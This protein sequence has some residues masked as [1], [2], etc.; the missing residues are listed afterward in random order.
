M[1][2][3]MRNAEFCAVSSALQSILSRRTHVTRALGALA[4]A[5][6]HAAGLQA[7]PLIN[8]QQIS[9]GS[10]HTCAIV[11]GRVQCWGF[12]HDGQ[13]GNGNYLDSGSPVPVVG[14]GSGV[15]AIS[16]G[17]YHTCAL[18]SGLV[19]CWG[20]NPDGELG[21]G[22]VAD[23]NVP[24]TVL[25][26]SGVIAIRA[27]QYHTCAITVS[28]AVRCWGWNSNG[29]LG[30][31]STSAT[32]SGMPTTVSGIA[33][34]ATMLA[35]GGL[36][37]CAL[38]GAAVKCW[39]YNLD[40]ELGNGSIADSHVPVSVNN[41]S[42]AT[43]IAAGLYHTCAIVGGGAVQCWGYNSNGQLGDTS[44]VSTGTG[45]AVAVSGIAAGTTALAGGGYHTCAIVGGVAKCWG[46]NAIGALG[47]G[48]FVESHV[49]MT[50]TGL[51]SNVTAIS[52]GVFH[53][54]A[55]IT[56][57]G[58]QQARC[59][60]DNVDGEIGL[61]DSIY[62]STP[63]F[64]VGL[65]SGASALASGAYAT[66]SCAIV[67]GSAKCWGNNSNGQLGDGT[68]VDSSVPVAVTGLASAVTAISKGASHTCAVVA[69][70]ALCWGANAS[71]Q[72]G[73]AS[74]I[75]ATTP[76]TAIAS[77]VTAVAA[78]YSHSCA[79][80]A[81]AVKCW[82]SNLSGELGNGST[83]ESHVPVAVVNLI[84]TP[85]AISIGVAHTCAVMSTGKIQCWG[86]N[87]NGQLGNNSNV[88]TGS[89]GPTT[90]VSIP[91]GATAVAA[92]G[93]HTCAIVSGGVACWGDG[94]HGELGEG[95]LFDSFVPVA[96]TGLGS[97]VSGVFAGDTYSCA[98]AAGTAYCW[99]DTHNI[100]ANSAAFQTVP[101]A[102]P[103][104]NTVTSIGTGYSH[105]CAIVS[106][107]TVCVG[108]DYFGELGDGRA[109]FL[110]VPGVTVEGDEI[111]HDN[112][113][114]N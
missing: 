106:G 102:L 100:G 67:G 19:K 14:L 69:G 4:L 35:G 20:R 6:W 49:P 113:E 110:K 61:G 33:S 83:A 65:T 105:G 63:A 75:D 96:P 8:V 114:A 81:A 28:G 42:G 31:G 1:G 54:C 64:V 41:V 97:G 37:T 77:G 80:V 9:N 95:F 27:G 98:I 44:V 7:S 87:S 23:S 103:L 48:T 73:N 10:F 66:H 30:D 16:S 34:G 59:W 90:V 74:T 99:G 51:T 86:Y 60:G 12:N 109:I 76:V 72:L 93:Y 78:G 94:Q 88:S 71:G 13:L 56:V 32:N 18:V 50:V 46:D 52:A 101:A 107:A 21:N 58:T 47:V 11:A 68:K 15:T 89:N 17:G 38:I 5:L 55:L 40:G 70:K 104:G 79:I 84:G 24:V 29:Q 62:V 92:G 45:A 26:L 53:S 111:F 43:S 112:F 36:H 2:V 22:S 85:T 82:G 3:V 57:S 39:G 25:G 91:S 108:T